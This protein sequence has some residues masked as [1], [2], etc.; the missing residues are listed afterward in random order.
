M[1]TQAITSVEAIHPSLWR[2]SQLARSSTVCVGS[3]HASLD[4][5][6]PGGGWPAGVL[7]ELLIQ[8]NG[9]AELSLLHLALNKLAGRRIALVQPP[10]QPQSLALSGFGLSPAQFMW[11]RSKKPGDALWASE[12]ILRTGSCGA[13]L[14]WQNHIRNESLRRLHLAAQ[15]NDTL[16]FMVRPLAC[17]GQ[18]SPAALRLSLQPVHQGLQISFTKR[19]GASRDVP[20]FL[21]LSPLL[22]FSD[23]AL[24]D[25]LIPAF[26]PAGSISPALAE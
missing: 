7:I 2:V 4:R 9:A 14:L 17:A 6:L 10:H 12:Q 13:L 3:G 20:L 25:S 5:E 24:V 23:H 21:S 15:S 1:Q 22:R 16:F 19:R 26:T 18:P 11:I 8:Q